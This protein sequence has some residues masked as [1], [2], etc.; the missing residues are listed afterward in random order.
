MSRPATQAFLASFLVYL[1]PLVGLH[2]VQLW[3]V[4]LGAELS[5]NRDTPLWLAAVL[6][7]ALGL[8]A[9]WGALC[10]WFALNANLKR[11]AVLLAAVPVLWISLTWIYWEAIPRY[12]LVDDNLPPET[13]SWPEHCR[14]ENA[15][16]PDIRTPAAR[17]TS[18]VQ[19]SVCA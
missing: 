11:L 5:V 3:G 19:S 8:Q 14:V 6:A 10:Y 16:L 12:F 9:V 17:Y 15:Y 13:E 4:V 7:L 1:L 2:G 18:A